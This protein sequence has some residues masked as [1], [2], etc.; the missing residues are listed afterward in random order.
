MKSLSRLST[1]DELAEGA[2][3]TAEAPH[4]I[5]VLAQDKATP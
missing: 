5:G 4:H 3:A 1:V 2:V